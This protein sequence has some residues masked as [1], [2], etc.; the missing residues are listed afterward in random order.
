MQLVGQYNAEMT[1]ITPAEIRFE[2]GVLR[3][4]AFGDVYHSADGGVAQ[5]THVFLKGNGLPDRWL[6]SPVFQILETGFGIGLNFL[7]AWNAWRN[8]VTAANARLHFVSFEKFPLRRADL[9]RVLRPYPTLA[10]QAEALLGAWPPL[11]AGF[12]QLSFEQGRVTL[13]LVLGD[14]QET[15]PQLAMAA[16]AIFLDGFS[17][18]K[19]PQMW[20]DWVLRH[21]ARQAVHQATL[22][23]WCVAGVVRRSLEAHGFTVQRHPGFGR[24]RERLEARFDR[25]PAEAFKQMVTPS[26][27]PALARRYGPPFAERHALVVGAGISGCLVAERLARHGWQ[28]DLF[29]RHASPAQEASGNPAGILRPVLSRDDN[30]ASRLGRAAFFQTLHTL[31]HL[32]DRTGMIRYK[33]CGVLVLA[34]DEAEAAL[35]RSV[36]ARHDY[37]QDYVQFLEPSEAQ[38]LSGTPSSWGGW[39]FPQ[40]GWLDPG[41]LCAAALAAGASQI[42]AHWNTDVARIAHSGAWRVFDARGQVLAEAPILILALGAHAESLPQTAGLPLTLFRGQITQIANDPFPP[43]TPVLCQDGYVISGLE[44]GLCVGAT[45]DSDLTAQPSAA[46]TQENLARLKRFRPDWVADGLA[47]ADRVGFR[48]TSR[49]RMPLVG[50]LP[51][52]DGLHTVMGMG[53]RGLVWSSMAAALIIA[54]L[55]GT[56]C[57][58]EKDLIRAIAPARFGATAPTDDQ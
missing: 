40:G 1:T 45:Y 13:T 28:I 53:S 50:A 17:P 58:L 43:Q 27:N 42:R 24:K 3:A 39:Y 2:D 47:T 9:A 25:I 57:P 41:S 29:D 32:Q 37:P 46:A 30:L 10:P 18:E 12:H 6:H 7:V 14:I 22:A 35:Q 56:P 21:V 52:G 48:G 11:V 49:D 5:S 23:T 16:D 54:E 26:R 55:E 20:D 44:S 38:R 19:N 15:L 34:Q 4:P 36:I 51:A 33:Q 31:T 8:T